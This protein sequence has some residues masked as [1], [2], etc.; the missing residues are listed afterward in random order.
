MVEEKL[1][2]AEEK[3]DIAKQGE[4]FSKEEGNDIQNMLER[5]NNAQRTLLECICEMKDYID[6][7]KRVNRICLQ[8]AATMATTR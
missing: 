8:W 4:N 3:L 6:S 7:A 2:V 1:N 5:Y